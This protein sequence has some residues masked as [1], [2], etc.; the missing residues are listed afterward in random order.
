[1]AVFHSFAGMMKIDI[2]SASAIDTLNAI[3]SAGVMVFEILQKDELSI[4]CLIFRRDIHQLEALLA[5]RG[6]RIQQLERF[7]F[8]W[9]LAGLRKRAIFVI[10]MLLLI[11]LSLYIPTRVLFVTVEGNRNISTTRI[12][13]EAET[14]GIAF[15]ASRREVRSEKVK[16]LLLGS[17]PELQ[18]AGVNTHGCVAVISV[19]ERTQEEKTGKG[20]GVSSVV[21]TRDGIIQSITATAGNPLC[22]IGQAVKVG[23]VLISGYT[24][25]GIKIQAQQASGE[26]MAYTN[27][28]LEVVSPQS[29]TQKGSVTG[30]KTNYAIIFGK[31]L[32]N[33]SED[34][35]IPDSSCDKIYSIKYLTL[36]GGFTLPFGVVIE[37]YYFRSVSNSDL[38]ESAEW[39]IS[40]ARSYVRS[41]M[42]AGNILSEIHLQNDAYKI[43]IRYNC[44]EMI[45]R[46]QKEEIIKGNGE[47]G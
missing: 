19:R 40:Y 1:M 21:A 45:G 38:Q 7:G 44:L 4:E 2:I 34:S 17:I 47:T 35:G 42:V 13:D 41:Q 28:D 22:R 16:N 24:D 8:Y 10:G 37:R 43:R 31:K 18:W 9:L 33:L 6:A 14:C 11:A 29:M 39:M 25:C 26:V 30:S 36:P 27:R 3:N 5:K 32:I 46:V 23:Q 12:L 15:G 20:I